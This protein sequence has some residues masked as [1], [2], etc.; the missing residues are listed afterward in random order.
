MP[1]DTVLEHMGRARWFIHLPNGPDPCPRTVIEA[2]I[3]GCELVV[4]KNV[5]RVPVSGA[6]NVAG[7]VSTAAERFW[8]WVRN[9]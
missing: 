5:G 7:F 6:D 3:A 8:G 2:E 1:R 9:G 4:N